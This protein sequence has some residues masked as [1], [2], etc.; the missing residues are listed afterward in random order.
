M[1]LLLFHP[2]FALRGNADVFHICYID[3]DMAY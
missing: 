3:V 2:H 1:I